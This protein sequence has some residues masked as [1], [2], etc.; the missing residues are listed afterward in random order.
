M[1]QEHGGNIHGLSGVLDFSAN[2]NPL[3]M[4]EGVRNAIAASAADCIIYPDPFCNELRE[5]LG[6]ML[7]CDKQN[8]VCGNGA[9]DLI[10][11]IVHAFRP[12]NA[13]ICAPTFGEYKKA[14][15]ECGCCV[16]E[17]VLSADNDFA[18]TDAVLDD[19]DGMDMV[20]LCSP[21]NPT[22]QLIDCELMKKIADTC[23]SKGALLVCDECFI[24]F[25]EERERFSLM[26]WL[27][28]HCIVISALTKLYAMPGVRLGFAVCGCS[29]TADLLSK[30]GQF[31]SVSAPAQA[32][33]LA[34]LAEEWYV[35][36]TADYIKRERKYLTDE[37][38]A[39]GA[40]VFPSAANFLL[41]RS[42][43]DLCERL[44]EDNIIIRKCENF[45]GLDECFFRIAIR[46]HDENRCLVKSFRRC[47]NG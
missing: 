15:D 26:N 8:I 35:E 21:N 46:T 31:W 43:P 14:L 38:S 41:I 45:S 24:G 12:K 34:A 28:E 33:G 42:V 32:A 5:A 20:F 13:L 37:L 23:S 1:L 18:L 36:R 22:G 29:Q 16:K 25:V 17:H 7:E 19:I 9:A 39:C 27:N 10:Y 4:I 44:M 30:S 3:G 11:R 6:V 2:I 40:E 47:L